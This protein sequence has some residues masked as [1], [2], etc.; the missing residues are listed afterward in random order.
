MG[1]TYRLTCK[2]CGNEFI[3]KSP[4]TF[5][6][7]NCYE[8]RYCKKCN[9]ISNKKFLIFDETEYVCNS[10][11]RKEIAIKTSKQRIEAMKRNGTF[12]KF[13]KAGTKAALKAWNNKTDEEKRQQLQNA[14]LKTKEIWNNYSDEERIQRVSPMIEAVKQRWKDLPLDK[15]N[16]HIKLNKSPGKCSICGK[17]N[18]KRDQNARGIECQCSQ[19]ALASIGFASNFI[20]KNGIE[21]FLDKLTNQYI[22]WSDFKDKFNKN[23]N[24]F[25][26][27]FN[28]IKNEFEVEI[29][30]TFITKDSPKNCGHAAFDKY[31]VERNINYFVYIKFYIDELG[32][33]KPLVVGESASLNIN[34]SGSDL[35]FSKDINHGPSRR[36][37]LEKNLDYYYEHILVIRTNSKDE[38]LLIEKQIKEKYGLYTS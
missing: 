9:K 16:E 1:K 11:V 26:D 36:F 30:P 10:C 3:G 2:H 34:S 24:S 22:P 25:N 20:I 7:N 6:C 8:Y 33:I 13:Q 19:K 31:L 35:S 28:D 18:E 14:H 17:F 32:E 15:R 21:Y 29:L 4:R 38:S 37:L 27:F 23:V 5:Y 12:E